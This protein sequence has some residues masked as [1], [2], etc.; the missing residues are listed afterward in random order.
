MEETLRDEIA[1]FLQ[2][3]TLLKGGDYRIVKSIGQG[4]FGI[5]YLAEQTS[6]GSKVCIKEFFA[7]ELCHLELV[8]GSP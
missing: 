5:T 4:G 3:G 7:K 6:L 1:Q 8:E 2:P